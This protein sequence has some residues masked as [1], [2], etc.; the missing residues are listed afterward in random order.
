M[1]VLHSLWGEGIWKKIE[2]RGL[3]QAQQTA[4]ASE[5]EGRPGLHCTFCHSINLTQ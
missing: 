4:E 2:V 1:N 3:K 5:S